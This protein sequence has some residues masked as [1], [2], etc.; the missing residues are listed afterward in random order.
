[1]GES[2]RGTVGLNGTAGLLLLWLL[3]VGLALL[4]LGS[5]P[6]RDWDEGIVAR[7]ALELANSPWPQH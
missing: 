2:S 4:G 7:V 3:A 5:V 6:L 1:M